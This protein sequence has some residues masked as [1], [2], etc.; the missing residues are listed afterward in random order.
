MRYRNN[1]INRDN[2]WNWNNEIY[3]DNEVNRDN[4]RNWD[5]EIIIEIE[6]ID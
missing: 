1:E 6:K 4:N 3:R 5:T 2:N